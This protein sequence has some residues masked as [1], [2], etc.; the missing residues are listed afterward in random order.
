MSTT[1]QKK[2]KKTSAKRNKK[3]NEQ[4]ISQT[5][6]VN[7]LKGLSVKIDVANAQILNLGL[8]VEYL[9]EKL[10]EAEVNL[11]VDNFP[12]W[13]EA[14][15]KEIQDQEET[16]MK[17]GLVDDLKGELEKAAGI[18]FSDET[19]LADLGDQLQEQ[20]EKAIKEQTEQQG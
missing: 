13:A 3:V 10:E 1:T 9:Y 18:N 15:H 6:T 5:E 16:M 7:I 20:L 17:D 11:D 2:G 4:I 14:R 12:T 8:L 19:K